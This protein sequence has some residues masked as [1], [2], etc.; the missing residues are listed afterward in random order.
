MDHRIQYLENVLHR[1]CGLIDGALHCPVPQDQML[2]GPGDLTKDSAPPSAGL[3]NNR[4]TTTPPVCQAKSTGSPGGLHPIVQKW[5][6]GTR[7]SLARAR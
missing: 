1:D 5:H 4:P 6:D 3:R 2:Q 7:T